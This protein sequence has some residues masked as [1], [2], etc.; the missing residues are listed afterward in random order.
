MR[1]LCWITVYNQENQ[2]QK[3]LKQL[4]D[5]QCKY[6]IDFLII[7]NGSTDESKKYILKSKYKSF[8]LKRN[9]G[10][11][12]S[13]ILSIKF[14]LKYDYKILVQLAGNNKMSPSD[15]PKMVEPIIN[16]R[17]EYVSGSRFY[18][19][20]NYKSNPLVR[21]ILIKLLTFFIRIL[22]K[23]K[24]T[25][26]TCGYRAFRVDIFKNKIKYFNKRKYYTYGFEYYSYGK[27]LNS[28]KIKSC[29]TSVTM[30]YDKKNKYSHIRPVVDWMPIIF[31]Y[32]A[33]KFDK[34]KIF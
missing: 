3:L 25:D 27:I 33:S 1:I 17:A 28:S 8:N 4:D 22:F 9:K 20:A 23:K 6:N 21:V 10:I 18:K 13:L 31:G 29:E 11:G 19:I 5:F 24:I 16:R 14:A 2:I 26:A 7:N 34:K 32:L 12:Y 30:S 15:I